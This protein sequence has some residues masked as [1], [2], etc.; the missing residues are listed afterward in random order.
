VKQH[1]ILDS[2][3]TLLGVAL[4]VVT[5][6]HIS[7]RAEA[8]IADELAFVAALLFLGSCGASHWAITRS[9]DRLERVADIIFAVA[10]LVLFISVLTLWI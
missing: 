5:A 8:T 2:A 10:L 9:A 3:A 4:V 7:G 6:V 1:Y